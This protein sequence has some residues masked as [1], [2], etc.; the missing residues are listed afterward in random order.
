MESNS[1]F[2]LRKGLGSM[3]SLLLLWIADNGDIQTYK[4]I[5]NKIFILGYSYVPKHNR[6]K[7]T[8]F[9]YGH[10]LHFGLEIGSRL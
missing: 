2:D 10:S 3:S 1:S 6:F 4:A 8:S 7:T 9:Y 5:Y